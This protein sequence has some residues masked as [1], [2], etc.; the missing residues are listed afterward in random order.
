MH[1]QGGRRGGRGP[2]PSLDQ[3]S[4]PR[5]LHRGSRKGGRTDRGGNLL[6]VS[7][8]GLVQASP[9]LSG[10]DQPVLFQSSRSETLE[11]AVGGCGRSAH[12]QRALTWS[13]AGFSYSPRPTP[14]FCVRR[15]APE[16][17]PVISPNATE[18]PMARK[19]LGLPAACPWS[20]TTAQGRRATLE[21]GRPRASE[22]RPDE[23]PRARPRAVARLSRP[24]D[25]N[26]AGRLRPRVRAY[27]VDRLR[28]LAQHADKDPE[29]VMLDFVRPTSSGGGS[30]A[31]VARTSPIHS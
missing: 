28:T 4:P 25:T 30:G 19:Y 22:P 9:H 17:E 29:T 24:L 5:A 10:A 27:V 18:T 11:R 15:G 26:P 12:E 14:P 6:P 31:D 1:R 13:S 3:T 21:Q 7:Q 2:G 20:A 8:V 16:R 23:K